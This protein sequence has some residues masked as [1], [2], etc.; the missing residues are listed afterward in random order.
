MS[1]KTTV[2]D[3]EG[4][5]KQGIASL[6]KLAGSEWTDFNA[7]D[8]GITILEQVCYAFTDLAYRIDYKMEDLLSEEGD[9]AYDSLYSPKQILVS[10]PVTLLDLRKLVIDVDGV[11][12]AWLEAVAEP[13]PAL[14]YQADKANITLT[15]GEGTKA[16]SLRGLY[17]VL[18]EKSEASD[19]DSNAIIRNVAERLHA[20]RSLAV[21]FET[22]QI[23]DSQDIR[24][25]TSIELDQN[26]DPDEVY[27]AILE[28]INAYL[29][30][31]LH[32][33]TLEACLAQGKSIDTILN[34]PLLDHG[35]IDDQELIGLQRKTN[36]YGSD[37]IREIMDIDG[38]RLVESVA[39]KDGD[40]F[41]DTILVLNTDKSPKLD[42]YHC[43][44]TLKKN[45][46]PVQLN[47]TLLAER[48]FS[49]Q[50]KQLGRSIVN[51][52]LPLP[53]GRDRRIGR[54][55]SLL[56]QFPANYGIGASG[57]PN[58]AS[59]ERKAQAK[60]LKAYLLFFDQLLANSFSQLAHFKDLFS[61][62]YDLP[63]DAKSP[64]SYFAACLDDPGISE[65][66]VEQNTDT[67]KQNLQQIF[68]PSR[69]GD[70]ETQQAA[71]WQRKN[72]FID[73]LLARF[74]EQFIDFSHYGDYADANRKVLLSKLALL[75]TYPQISSSKGTGFNALAA[76]NPDNRS[77][78]EQLLRLK[79]GFLETD[80]QL[81]VLEHA[82]LRPMAGDHSQQTPLL[83]EALSPDPYSLQLTVVFF[84]NPEH[85]EGYKC[86]VEQT[87]REETPAHLVVYVCW[88]DSADADDFAEAYQ[89]WQQQHSVYR[90]LSNQGILNGP[91]SSSATI[92]LRAARD[93]LLDLS[94]IGQTYPLRDLPIAEIGTVAYS[95]P[96][97]IVIRNS[98]Q[99][100]GYCLCDDLNKPL[101]PE[102]KETGN[103][104]DLELVS[105]KIVNDR[106]FSIQATKLSNKLSATL[107]QI[108]L[109]KVGLD[110]ALVAC[111]QKAPLLL[112]SPAPL[113]ND[114]RIIDYGVK[115][116]VAIEKSQE[117]VDYQLVKTDNKTLL[118]DTSIGNG[119][120]LVLETN[121]GVTEDIEIRIRCTKTFDASENKEPQTGLLTTVLP[122]K[123]KANPAVD[124][125]A[126]DPII[127]YS[128]TAAVTVKNSQA[129]ASYQTLTRRIADNEFIH[130]LASGAV[131]TVAVPNQEKVQL[132]KPS[133]A[134][135]IG[136]ESA[137]KSVQGNGNEIVLTSPTLTADSFIA[138]QAS[139]T[140]RANNGTEV[141]STVQLHQIAAILV[142][143][144]ADPALKFKASLIDS[145]LQAPIQVSGGQAGVFYEFTTKANNKVQGSPVY[146]HQPDPADNT[147]NK[148]IGQ[149]N[150]GVDLA[151][152]PNVPPERLVNNPKLAE[153]APEP[154]ELDGNVSITND[155]ELS[156][157]AIK[158]QTNVE[159]VFKRTASDLLIK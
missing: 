100:V 53:Q 102:V 51:S 92:P 143:P 81:Y 94:G 33:Y 5:R 64:I 97:R 21:D 6:E 104:H 65:L 112:P 80:A 157:R 153:L 116:Q 1:S 74:A 138:V 156:I 47:P 124:V 114:A 128:T 129:N 117:G 131:L 2:T 83:T 98:Q 88:L 3:Y 16:L 139:K 73:H 130:G 150:V 72:R 125:F 50:K 79:L 66:W 136:Q 123:V 127:G 68:G 89:N 60:Q 132:A 115:I 141:T 99:G 77:G 111:I 40:T 55:Y 144:N 75:R 13:Q 90:R 108:P 133:M 38:V 17:R 57:L 26:A 95:M 110:L 11:K 147:Q 126:A 49:H 20:R 154:P 56:Q 61:F 82:L 19:K 7:H 149:L 109:V 42:V 62:D 134:G 18:I 152:P 9:D 107:L 120:T 8:P 39:F 58:S 103:G 22:I 4:L 155:A 70:P 35:F 113:A 84:A 15:G 46:L 71:D 52:N 91:M 44:I 78:L 118:S 23:I 31:A 10:N 41:N 69:A 105:P 106:S 24:I 86:F 29:S 14:F 142:R 101:E 63:L 96:A 34:G 158:A 67:R 37:L 30:P 27:I 93:R 87:V 76:K 146:F 48:Y 28:K 122:L 45:Q 12:N 36:L 119:K 159:V 145:R 85:S 121:A 151:M 135:F 54:Y 140:H 43:R 25:Y 137:M 59:E 148:G 32:F